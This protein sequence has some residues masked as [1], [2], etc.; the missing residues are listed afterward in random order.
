MVVNFDRFSRFEKP[1]F[2]VCNPGCVYQD[3]LLSNTLGILDMTHDEQLV[4]NFGSTSQLDFRVYQHDKEGF[5]KQFESLKNRRLI[6]L[7]G[8]G[9]FVITEVEESVSLTNGRYKDISAVSCEAELQGKNIP[10]IEDGTYKFYDGTPDG[11]GLLEKLISSVP[12]WTI[13]HVD[14]TVAL[15]YRTFEDVDFSLNV[16]GFMLEQL[17]DAYECIFIFDT[18][19]RTVSVYD[20]ANFVNDTDI[21][22]TNNDLINELNVSEN[23]DDLY[24]ALSVTGS[25]ELSINAVNPLGTSTI[26]NFDYYID[27]MTPELGEKVAAWS[28]LVKEYSDDY[29]NLQKSYY[30]NLTESSTMHEELDKLNTQYEMY[31]K[32][33]DNC[34][35][36]TSQDEISQYNEIIVAVGGIPV[37]ENEGYTWIKYADTNWGQ[38]I[39]SDPYGKNYIGIAYDKN[40]SVE[41]LDASDYEWSEFRDGRAIA[42]TVERIDGEETVSETTYT[43]VVFADSSTS[44]VGFN[45][46]KKACIGISIGNTT[47]VRPENNTDY[48]WSYIN[49]GNLGIPQ[50]LAQLTALIESAE[51]QIAAKE[52]EIAELDATLEE[53]KAEA[54]AIHEEVAIQNYFTDAELQ[55][56]QNYIFEGTYTDEY[57]GVTET[58][59]SAERFDQMKIL[60]DRSIAQ[61]IKV[62]TPT[63]E[64][65]VDVENFVFQ[66]KFSSWSAQLQTGCIINVELEDDDVAPLFLSTI[67]VNYEDK[68]LSLTFGNRLNRFDTKSLFDD[69]LGKINKAS[70][71]LSYIRDTIYPI[72]N[73][74]FN[75]MKEALETSKTLTKNSVLSSKNEQ[76]VIDDTGYT[77]R[78]LMPDGTLDPHQIKINGRNIV[79]TDDAWETCKTAIGEILLGDGASSYGINAEIIL[80][81]LIMGNQLRII[82]SD[83]QDIFAV[84]DEKI[85]ASL[86]GITDTLEGFKSDIEI[87]STGLSQVTTY[88]NTLGTDLS[89]FRQYIKVGVL[90]GSEGGADAEYGVKIGRSD[91]AFSAKFTSNELGFYES[92]DKTAFFSNNKLNVNNVRTTKIQMA[93]TY[94]DLISEIGDG[95]INNW[96][97]D[98]EGGFSLRWIGK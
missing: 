50:V 29:Y 16:L 98:A 79:F 49:Q 5:P 66:Q 83:G 73:G 17:Q 68:E 61:L 90:D 80:G 44:T 27:W 85:T 26:Y 42:R 19:N 30:D 70:N 41:S 77:G 94:D 56:L 31:K 1:N 89:E 38:N 48:S 3:G 28:S 40:T 82:N 18:T 87:N 62:S 46:D 69:T 78:K 22:I 76:V 52:A 43:F 36:E 91:N 96:Q 33:R 92:E 6:Y 88:A 97:I 8:I 37:P 72:K 12:M 86:D 13:D 11:Q 63:Q 23:S 9:F 81:D 95:E 45:P 55:E 14:T 4:F 57:I 58:M 20:Q 67:E 7:D 65:S 74:E 24:T 10:Y 75:Q 54:A 15:R 84:Q 59:T 35:A 25:D 51:S 71:T 34:V 47:N 93:A 60:Y 53:Q 32:C 21:H 39:T 64:F 2:Y